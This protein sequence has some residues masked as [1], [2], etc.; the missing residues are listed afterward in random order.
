[1]TDLARS[2]Q[3]LD[4]L[5]RLARADAD[6]VRADLADIE[7]ARASAE[8]SMAR[9][10]ETARR[11]EELVKEQAGADFVA[12]LEGVRERQRNLQTTMMTLAEAEEGAHGRLEAAHIEIKK[13][14]HL[15]AMNE[16]ASRKAAARSERL[17]S[18][19]AAAARRR[20]I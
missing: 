17:A 10:Q 18:D 6:A 2:R 13:L 19:E 16:R 11:E 4:K 5:L 3:S 9:L 8:S 20:A 12:Y 14:E 15:I 1:M 7:C